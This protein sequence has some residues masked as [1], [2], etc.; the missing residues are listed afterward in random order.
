M[1]KI[2]FW[3]YVCLSSIAILFG[4]YFIFILPTINQKIIESFNSGIQTGQSQVISAMV[5]QY[6]RGKLT[7]VGQDGTQLVMVPEVKGKK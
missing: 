1:K 5:E 6:N 2:F 3:A 7:I 4:S